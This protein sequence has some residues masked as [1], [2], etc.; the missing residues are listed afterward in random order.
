[1][2]LPHI[3]EPDGIICFQRHQIY[4]NLNLP[5]FVCI[6]STFF[7]VVA[8]IGGR[9]SRVRRAAHIVNAPSQYQGGCLH[10]LYFL[11]VY[12]G[13]RYSKSWWAAHRRLRH[14]YVVA[15]C[16]MILAEIARNC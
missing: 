8:H 11:F 1:M 15:H 14:W 9:S 16:S 4:S 12:D 5:F 10:T 3:R 6:Y 7:S 2:S 13:P